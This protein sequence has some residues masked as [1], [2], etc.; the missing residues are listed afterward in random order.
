MAEESGQERTERAT[1]K[2]LREAREKG[3]I[4]RSRELNN[5]VMMLAASGGLVLLGQG[6]LQ[7]LQGIL[8]Q[9]FQVERDSLFDPV[10]M[11][12]SFGHL[13]GDALMLLAPFLLLMIVAAVIGPL[14]IGGWSFSA[15][16]L[17]LKWERL[18]PV[19]GLGKIFSWRGL[20]E[21]GKALAKFAVVAT[22]AVTLLWNLASELLGLGFE[23][24]ER[25][26]DHAVSLFVKAFIILSA[27]LV[28]IAA[29]DVPFQL[30]DYARQ[31][32]MTR[33][34]VKDEFK[35]TEGRPEVKSR[36]RRLQRELAQRRM[37]EEVPKADVVITNPTH[38]A[39]ALRY[40][41]DKMKAP[42][43][44][45]KGSD[46]VAARIRAVAS[47]HRV[48][49]FSA[50]PL[51]RAIYFSTEIGRE[52]PAGLYVAVAQVLAYVY[53]LKTWAP[54]G[55]R[56]EPPADLPVPEEFLKRGPGKRA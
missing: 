39:V 49:I 53:Q 12:Q 47:E 34:E 19:K 14:A 8:R 26:F 48:P 29:V 21:L 28:L 42:R 20:V 43:V 24:Y 22:V 6:M 9:A 15:Q 31:L 44:V 45:A 2:R 17:T 32:R 54:G 36:I 33:Q 55:A 3:Q 13:F 37:M 56:P 40:D 30:W 1:G 10:A 16:A 4:P 5:M 50:P 46:L 11:L 18:N 38:Y 52:I 35:E 41:Q 7:S 23:P 51:A 25:A 27:S